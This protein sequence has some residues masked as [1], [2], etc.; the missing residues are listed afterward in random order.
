MTRGG[1][2]SDVEQEWQEAAWSDSPSEAEQ[3]A[4]IGAKRQADADEVQR[5]VEL[6]MALSGCVV[7]VLVLA[8]LNGLAAVLV[9]WL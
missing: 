4:A 1:T 2:R 3:A 8:L 5:K 7:R 9:A 6:Q